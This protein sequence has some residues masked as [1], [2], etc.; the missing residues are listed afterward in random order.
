MKKIIE[1]PDCAEKI[2]IWSS[3]RALLYTVY[4]NDLEDYHEEPR[5]AD[6]LTIC[7]FWDKVNH[8]CSNVQFNNAEAWTKTDHSHK[9]KLL[10][11][12]LNHKTLKRY[13]IKP[14]P[15]YIPWTADTAPDMFIDSDGIVYGK[16]FNVKQEK[17]M[18]ASAIGVFLSFENCYKER[19]Q[20]DG[21]PCGQ[22]VED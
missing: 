5:T 16:A 8:D 9:L 15:K 21:T 12:I 17:W 1:F 19:K 14:E 20:H 22:K 3:P 6:G 4:I 18:Y 7:E 10:E 2:N 13:R 11:C